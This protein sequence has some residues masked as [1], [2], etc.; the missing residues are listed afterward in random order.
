MKKRDFLKKLVVGGIL[1]AAGLAS[2]KANARQKIDEDSLAELALVLLQAD[3]LSEIEELE[4]LQNVSELSHRQQQM[5]ASII[6]K[7]AARLSKTHP[8]A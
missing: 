6:R 2:S 7:G 3:E 4:R 8:W 5:L 1:S